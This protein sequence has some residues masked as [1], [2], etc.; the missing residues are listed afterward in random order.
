MTYCVGM[1]LAE[2]VVLI[3]DT[4]TNA[5]VDNISTYSKLFTFIPGDRVIG[6]MTAGNL[7]IS[8]S[9]V[10]LVT[11][12]MEHA[13]TG[14]IETLLTVGSMFEAAQLV[15]RAVREVY[16]RDGEALTE[17]GLSFDATF[18]VAGQI[19]GRRQRMFQI[20]S[21][22]NFIESSPDTPF[23]QLGETKYGK[24]ILDR[25]CKYETPLWDAVKL[26]MISMDS[27]LR[28]NLSVGLPID[29]VVFRHDAITLALQHRIN[30]DDPYFRAI[31]EGWSNA[32]TQAYR[33]MPLPPWAADAQK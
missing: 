8:Q 7:A 26:A 27:T 3:A 28:S 11:E 29:L 23:M 6:L 30:D 18:I 19:R 12:G 15:G 2:G 13:D 21:A 25:V 4:R 17:R 22:G 10:T 9:V 16:K 5:G 31:R 20:Y 33:M 1:S 24:P 32:L 14:A